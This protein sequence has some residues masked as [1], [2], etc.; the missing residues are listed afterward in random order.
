ML[1]PCF[2]TAQAPNSEANLWL[3]TCDAPCA[4]VSKRPWQS[5]YFLLT[6]SSADGK[7]TASVR[8][9]LY[10][11][12][13]GV[14]R[15]ELQK[16]IIGYLNDP[17]DRAWRPCLVIK[18]NK[19]TWEVFCLAL[20]LDLHGMAEKSRATVRA[21]RVDDVFDMPCPSQKTR[22]VPTISTFGFLIVKMSWTILKKRK[23]DQQRGRIL[24]DAFFAQCVRLG[25]RLLDEGSLREC[26]GTGERCV[27][28]ETA[29]AAPISCSGRAPLPCL[30]QALG[31]R[32]VFCVGD[33]SHQR[34][35]RHSKQ[36]C[37]VL[38]GALRAVEETVDDIVL[39]LAGR[40]S[41]PLK[42]RHLTTKSGGQRKLCEDYRKAL[43]SVL[44]A[45]RKKTVNQLARADGVD[46]KRP[47][48]TLS[49]DMMACQCAD[50]RTFHDLRGVFRGTEDGTR[51]EEP[52]KEKIVYLAIHVGT[53]IAMAL[54]IQVC[55]SP[56]TGSQTV[57]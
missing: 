52:A 46:T 4:L 28:L 25:E 51:M 12:N 42:E 44:A 14:T 43:T 35:A 23:L 17:L 54:P 16:L 15:W 22:D 39:T 18:E 41:D 31:Q 33:D 21:T 37:H 34:D 8:H 20:G 36:R 1:E 56:N 55:G 5:H 9:H 53:N 32:V 7:D 57:V 49:K 2:A 11:H 13:D 50:F 6:A 27:H 10:K 38:R 40:S 24:F 45:K 30:L 47:R 48:E 29:F 26:S 3:P 19:L